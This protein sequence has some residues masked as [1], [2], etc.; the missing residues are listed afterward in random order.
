MVFKLVEASPGEVSAGEYPRLF[1]AGVQP[2]CRGV[3]DEVGGGD[4]KVPG[5]GLGEYSWRGCRD[6]SGS[7]QAKDCSK[8]VWIGRV[9]AGDGDRSW[10]GNSV[11]CDDDVWTCGDTSGEN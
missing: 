4:R 2:F 6:F 5:G 8:E 9:V 10:H 3:W 1:T 11:E 7:S